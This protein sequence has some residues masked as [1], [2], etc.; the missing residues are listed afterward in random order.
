ME[1][2]SPMKKT[3]W[4]DIFICAFV[5]VGI[6]FMWVDNRIHTM[7][8]LRNKC[9]IHVFQEFP[10]SILTQGD[11]FQLYADSLHSCAQQYR[12]WNITY[13]TI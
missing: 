5:V 1:H 7:Y 9:E 4:L 12:F 10:T 8:D 6:I 2:L 11:N 13:I 3:S